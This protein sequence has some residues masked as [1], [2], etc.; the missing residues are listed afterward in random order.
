LV[1]GSNISAWAL[2]L[3]WTHHAP[4][5]KTFPSNKVA[6]PLEALNKLVLPTFVIALFKGL[7]IKLLL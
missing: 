1:F 3:L 2:A 6:Q 4:A 5:I 7:K